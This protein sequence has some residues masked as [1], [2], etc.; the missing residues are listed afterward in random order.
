M[1]VDTFAE[2][3]AI[4][5]LINAGSEVE[6]RDKTIIMLDSLR[7]V[8]E[9]YS[10]LVNSIIRSVGLYPYLDGDTCDWTDRYA[11]EA[12][13]ADVGGE[14]RAV[15]HREQSRLLGKLLSGGDIAVSAPTS[16]GK[17]F[18]ID[19]FIAIKNPGTVMIL[20]P[21]IALMDE[22]RRR[23]QSKFG[24]RYKIITSSDQELADKTMFIF[25]Q[26]RALGY[27]EKINSI[28]L[29]VVDEFY[30]AGRVGKSYDGERSS[31][32]I[33]AVVDL[34]PKCSQRYFL[35]PNVSKME[36]TAIF[37][38]DVEFMKVDFNTVFL[39]K[40]DLH[41]QIGRDDGKRGEALLEILLSTDAKSLVYAGTY[42]NID[43]VSLLINDNLPELDEILL[44]RFSGW[45]SKNYTPTWELVNLARRGVGVHNGSLHR[46]LAQIQV[47]LFERK[48]GLNVMVSTSSIIEGVNTSAENVILWSNKSGVPKID[49]FTFKNIIGRGGRMF[50]HFIGNIY[51][52][53][54]PP[55]EEGRQL[56]LEIPEE[57]LGTIDE[58]DTPIELTADQIAKIAAY[59]EEMDSLLGPGN[60]DF[61]TK[62]KSF[63]TCNSSVILNI[64]QEMA[65]G[66]SSWGDLVMLNG[67]DVE[68]WNSVLYKLIKLRPADWGK[69]GT[70]VEFVKVLAANWRKGIPDLLDELDIHD[71]GINKFFSLERKVCFNLSS[72]IADAGIIYNRIHQ[73]AQIDLS[74]AL[75]KFS[76][77]FLPKNV[78]L[79]EEYGLPRML[80]RKIHRSGVVDLEDNER[81]ILDVIAVLKGLGH[82]QICERTSGLDNFDVLVIEWFLGGV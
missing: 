26:E 17:S 72:L 67:N 57:M 31:A 69:H 80:S 32:L 36:G 45:L 56:E 21:T 62:E 50:R 63:K 7:R 82:Q 66:S 51:I 47:M 18:V 48:D 81:D 6:A 77:S 16:F 12:F 54:R 58:T 60:Y 78:Y 24:N 65:G 14:S 40:H 61:F 9:P 22:T 4:N 41:A 43:K 5:D 33:Q 2:C 64:A 42:T 3:S 46:S 30:K 79:L 23:I 28:D 27:V 10:P 25:P 15:L 39:R 13:S 8:G 68:S 75:M 44:S 20:V 70:F 74:P 73:S 34:S 55:E 76:H 11:I 35:A 59:R 53:A 38:G 49:D 52:L 19:A 29:L 37:G 1:I 71:V